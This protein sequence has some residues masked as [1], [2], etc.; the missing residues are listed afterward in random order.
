MSAFYILRNLP[1][2]AL[3]KS[4][5][6]LPQVLSL[7]LLRLGLWP[8]LW[9]FS[10]M[11][12]GRAQNSLFPSQCRVLSTLFP[13]K[14]FLSPHHIT[15]RSSLKIDWSYRYDSIPKCSFSLGPTYLSLGHSQIVFVL[16]YQ[17]PQ[18]MW[19]HM[20]PGKSFCPLKVLPTCS[21]NT[22]NYSHGA[23]AIYFAKSSEVSDANVLDHFR[24]CVRNAVLC[25]WPP[26]LPWKWLLAGSRAAPGAPSTTA[27]PGPLLS[28]GSV[29]SWCSVCPAPLPDTSPTET[30]SPSSRLDNGGGGQPGARGIPWAS[31]SRHTPN[32]QNWVE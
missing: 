27:S 26:G 3:W 23:L 2:W 13:N 24:R 18:R 9:Q 8:I 6:F 17:Y 22:Q 15:L 7:Q 25:W 19:S 31:F 1:P 10:G 4:S 14:T 16:G 30:P 5:Y 32:V 11:V 21:G 12:W 28:L 20:V 29:S